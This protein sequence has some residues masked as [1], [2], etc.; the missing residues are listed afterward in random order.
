MNELTN[1]QQEI[2]NWILKN[3]N[4]GIVCIKKLLNELIFT[5]ESKQ[6]LIIQPLDKY[7]MFFVDVD[8]FKS[9]DKKRNAIST[10]IEVASFINYLNFHGYITLFKGEHSHQEKILFFS[11][12]FSN[13]HLEKDKIVLNDKGLHST[14]PESI[15][16][17]NDEIIFKGVELKNANFDLLFSACVGN[18]T[19]SDKLGA[20]LKAS[21]N[22]K[23]TE[24]NNSNEDNDL[25]PLLT[26]YYKS[27]RLFNFI[28]SGLFIALISSF[29][30]Y[31][32]VHF[33]ALNNRMEQLFAEFTHS[34]L[35]STNR[36][37]ID[38]SRWN[39]D[40]A[41][42]LS[43]S[44]DIKFVI[45]KATEGTSE[46]DPKF[47]ENWHT[48]ERLKLQRGAYHFYTQ[49]LDPDAQANHYWSVVK[50]LTSSD[51]AP[52]VDIETTSLNSLQ[53]T[54]NITFQVDLLTLLK[55]LEKLSG[56]KP[57]IYTSVD[58]A[59]QFI[60]HSRFAE[61]PLWLADY[62]GKSSP[63]LPDIWKD[64]GY[65]IWQKSDTYS[66]KSKPTDFD[67]MNM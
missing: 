17:G 1:K 11:E 25:K 62:N 50:S 21:V 19:V 58:F 18:F 60:T 67:I 61:Y 55:E 64:E 22:N 29:V 4:D 5:I 27:L 13:P 43:K 48:L 32:K 12:V 41:V 26:S 30:V 34:E 23:E 6:C 31:S 3:K 7:A 9:E 59:N 33:E 40:I 54:S 49:N 35:K 51:I 14:K 65:F 56:R 24:K 46:V 52:I 38:I 20:L 66:L 57:I 28:L 47:V 45:A 8:D 36:Y 44:T 42:D 16:D 39:G 63:T 2:V 53:P 10:L 37:G 15:K